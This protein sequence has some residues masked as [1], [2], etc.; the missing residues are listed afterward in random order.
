M[1]CEISNAQI[2]TDNL[3]WLLACFPSS[4]SKIKRHRD[5]R[6]N[7]AVMNLGK[8]RTAENLHRVWAYP[9]LYV[10]NFSIF[11]FTNLYTHTMVIMW[12]F[13]FSRRRVW[14]WLSFWLLDRVVW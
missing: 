9:C 13:R 6:Y 8:H 2:L 7:D 3:C 1:V 10:T 5:I 4:C 14:R 12:H 11:H